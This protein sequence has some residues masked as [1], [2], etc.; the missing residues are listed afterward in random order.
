MI[1]SNSEQHTF[2]EGMAQSRWGKYLSDVEMAALRDAL[3]RFD[4]PA[5]ALEIGCEGGRWSRMLADAGWSTTCTDIDPD[6]LAVCQQRIPAARCLLSAPEDQRLPVDDESADLLLSIEVPIS[7]EPWFAEEVARVLRPGGVAV[8]TF[9]NRRSYRGRLVNLRW[10]LGGGEVHYQADYTTCR[11]RLTEAG[12]AVCRETGFAWLPFSRGSDSPLVPLCTR[13][14][15]QIWLR[16]LVH[17]SPCRSEERRVWKESR[18]R[19]S[20]HH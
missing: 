12:F 15:R 1:Q 9:H 20:P 17:H 14:E 16:R 10:L 3:S 6:A 18:S 2:W 19:L 13:L 4:A 5:D 8:C 11:R 7:E